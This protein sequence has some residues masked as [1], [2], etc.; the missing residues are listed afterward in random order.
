MAT[1]TDFVEAGTLLKPGLIGRL[2][3]LVLGIVCLYFVLGLVVDGL[4][5][6]GWKVPTDQRMWFGVLFGLW[7]FSYVVNIGFTRSWGR[8]P[9]AAVVVVAWG[10]WIVGMVQNGSPWSPALGWFVRIWL[11]Y[12]YA[13]LGVSFI[14]SALIATPGC[15]M[16]A[17]P[18]LWTIVTGQDTAEHYCPG[19]LDRI[20]RWEAERS[21]TK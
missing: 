5:L 7:V 3:R 16:R 2:V 15:E 11:L 4:G 13:H 9:T 1:E 19:A 14:L 18:H 21:E 17:L 8:N 20:D 6:V 12:T 10:I